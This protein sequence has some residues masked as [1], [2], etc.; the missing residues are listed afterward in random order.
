VARDE[1][2]AAW[3]QGVTTIVVAG[4][5]RAADDLADGT[6]AATRSDHV[7]IVRAEEREQLR[8]VLMRALGAGSEG[9]TMAGKAEQTADTG[10]T[11]PRRSEREGLRAM[12]EAYPITELQRGVLR[13]RWLSQ[14]EWM[15]RKAEQARSRYHVLRLTTVIGGVIVPALVSI[16]LGRPDVTPLLWVTFGISLVVALSAAVEGFFR[17]G[18]KWRHYRGTAEVLKSE[19]WQLL[20]GTGRYRKQSDPDEAFKS[21]MDRVEEILQSDVEGYLTQ[22]TRT[23]PSERFD[24]FT[25]V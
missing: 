16:S 9:P 4:S 1:T 20:T 25:R 2:V 22:V 10:S 19:G 6:H 13:E 12:I 11:A 18:E 15:S 23:T 21:F 3:Q 7:T 5:G 17:Y 8:S 24:V 14:V